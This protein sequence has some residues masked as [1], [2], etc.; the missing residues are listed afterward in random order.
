[1]PWSTRN[2]TWCTCRVCEQTLPKKY[3]AST[4]Q[5]GWPSIASPSVASCALSAGALPSRGAGAGRTA[6]SRIT[7]SAAG[8]IQPA[9]IAPRI[10]HALRQPSDSISAWHS[11]TTSSMPRPM[12]ELTMPSER[13]SR[14]ANWRCTITTAGTQP[15]HATASAVNR[16]KPRYRC[17]GES[18]KLLPYSAR[19]SAAP[20]N[21]TSRRGPMRSHSMPMSGL[22]PPC[23]RVKT[24]N[25]PASTE[26]LQPN[27]RSSATRNTLYEYHT[28]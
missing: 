9:Q 23:T 1:M 22:A 8:T 13:P 28:P 16:P 11:G 6:S 18:M 25:A 19:P 17:P 2:A 15:E 12:P 3:A 5:N 14:S 7:N 4:S 10:C 20:P 24:E 27:S 21:T 26:R